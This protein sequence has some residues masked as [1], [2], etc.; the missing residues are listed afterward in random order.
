MHPFYGLGIRGLYQSPS[1]SRRS[2]GAACEDAEP[3][4]GKGADGGPSNYD[5]EAWSITNIIL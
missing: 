5:L 2:Q 1:Q 4:S 3:A